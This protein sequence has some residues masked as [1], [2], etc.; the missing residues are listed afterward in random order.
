MLAETPIVNPKRFR[1][2][3]LSS[4]CILA[5][6][7]PNA[8][9]AAQINVIPDGFPIPS[10]SK[11]QP[12]FYETKEQTFD[13]KQ[14]DTFDDDPLFGSH[15]SSMESKPPSQDTDDQ[16]ASLM[17]KQL[18]MARNQLQREMNMMQNNEQSAPA[19]WNHQ[20]G[21]PYYP[22]NNPYFCQPT[23][24]QYMMHPNQF[25][26]PPFAPPPALSLREA[27]MN[28][29]SSHG[30]PPDDRGYMNM[31]GNYMRGAAM[32]KAATSMGQQNLLDEGYYVESD[33]SEDVEARF[34]ALASRGRTSSGRR[35]R[36]SGYANRN[37]FFDASDM[38]EFHD[39]SLSP[40]FSSRGSRGRKPR[41]SSSRALTFGRTSG[42][43][44]Q[45]PMLRD[46]T[47][48]DLATSGGNDPIQILRELNSKKS[49]KDFDKLI[50]EH[51]SKKESTPEE[52]NEDSWLNELHESLD[53]IGDEP[54]KDSALVKEK[55][56]QG[57]A[58]KS[59]G[60]KPEEQES[61]QAATDGKV[62]K[63]KLERA[64]RGFGSFPPASLRRKE[65][66]RSRKA[67]HASCDAKGK[68]DSCC[69]GGTKQLRGRRQH[70]LEPTS[71]TERAGSRGTRKSRSERQ[72]EES[73]ERE[74]E[75]GEGRARGEDGEGN[76]HKGG[77]DDEEYRRGE[78]QGRRERFDA[79]HKSRTKQI[80]QKLERA[81]RGF[82]SFPPA[83]L[84][85]K[86]A[87][88][89]RKA[90]HASCD[91]KGK[92]DSCCLGG[93]KQLRGRRQ[94]QLEP[95]STTERAGSRGTRKSRSERQGE[96][97]DE[98]ER[99]GGEG[100]ARGEDGEGNEHKGGEDDE[101]YRRGEDDEELK[102]EGGG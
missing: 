45:E 101:E 97:S 37:R 53:K 3:L 48:E 54:E 17:K 66:C 58:R 77:E 94:H 87:C 22:Y 70:Q 43:K 82:G 40:Q 65:A 18:H 79:S 26:Y 51:F 49:P 44:P 41:G 62:D 15:V 57:G 75:G 2:V 20:M 55:G 29:K 61:N 47:S 72:G 67:R 11:V 13:S 85:R 5:L 78:E 33:P 76:E 32:L 46:V 10:P 91:A 19:A 74:R 30:Q 21:Y 64:S 6:S 52:S 95:T 1:A 35:A 36:Q 34:R 73:D 90:R 99:E 96:E 81:S 7:W 25:Q 39:V 60:I 86:E 9:K 100:R 88:R 93:T 4:A 89:S 63:Q 31:G 59:K 8:C 24:G 28:S 84:R 27:L 12:T 14:R 102:C 68:K 92:K 16:M 80:K 71:T 38:D 98:R 56:A 50:L 23:N 69:L 42:R 83:S